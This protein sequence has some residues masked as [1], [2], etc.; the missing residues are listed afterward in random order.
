[1]AARL[2]NVEVENNGKLLT[3]RIDMS[4]AGEL[5]ESGKS[6]IIASTHGG[7]QLGDEAGTTLNLN[8]YKPVPKRRKQQEEE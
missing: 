2:N 3:L 1:M 8:L 4:K 7:L 5:S 6:L